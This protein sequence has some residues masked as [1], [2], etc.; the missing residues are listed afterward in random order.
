MSKGARFWRNVIL[1]GLAHVAVIVGLIRWSREPKNAS[2][3]SIVWMSGDGGDGTAAATKSAATPKPVK[4]TTPRP[5]RTPEPPQKEETEE[6][7][8]VLTSAKS[9]IQLPTPKPSPTSTSSPK[10][11]PTPKAKLTPKSTP[12]PTTKPT[13]KPTPKP[14]PKKTVLAK[15]SPKPSP[16]VK[17]T[18]VESEEND[19]QADADAEK[20]RIAK[21]ALA[22]NEPGDNDS[23]DD[24]LKKA[25]AVQGAA[26]KGTSPGG[27]GHAGGA[28]GQSQFGWYGSMLHDRFYSEWVQP[29]TIVSSGAKFSVLAKLRIQNDGR[30]SSFEIIK[31][32]GNA[33]VDESVATIAKRVTEVD[34]LPDG[35]GNGE[36]YDVNIN[37]ELNSEQ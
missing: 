18:P 8:P 13:P 26:G 17:P 28:G 30:V 7:R 2:A 25:R 10:A 15:A 12:K 5:E 16:K 32:S 22:K 33:T 27:G 14:S 19:E 3:Q 9:E 11:T 36:H 31:P 34:P 21:A 6:E 20:K 4:A 37:F 29:T 35:L 1:I 23:P 24:P